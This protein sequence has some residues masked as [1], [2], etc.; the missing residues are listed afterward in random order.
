MNLL[1]EFLDVDDIRNKYDML[2][3]KFEPESQESYNDLTHNY[4]SRTDIKILLQPDSFQRRDAYF[5]I[6]CKRLDGHKDLNDKYID[7]GVKR[8]ISSKYSSYYGKNFMIGFVVKNIKIDDNTAKIEELK[9]S[10]EDERLHGK[11]ELVYSDNNI[12]HEYI[13]KYCLLKEE[14]DLSHIFYNF[15]NVIK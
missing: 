2:N 9:N 15:S 8:F 14:I 13:C 6:E 7:N 3:F 5:N 10:S 12:V 11:F 4:G 1:N